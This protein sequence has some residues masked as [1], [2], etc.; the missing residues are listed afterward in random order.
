[1]RRYVTGK[2]YSP[3]TNAAPGH[4]V[5]ASCCSLR[6]PQERRDGATI[7]TSYVTLAPLQYGKL[8]ADV[9]ACCCR[10]SSAGGP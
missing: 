6:L 2:L 5:F 1:V 8:V 7:L 4:D 10:D 9:F 3:G